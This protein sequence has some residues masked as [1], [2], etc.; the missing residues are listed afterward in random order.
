MTIKLSP[1]QTKPPKARTEFDVHVKFDRD[2]FLRIDQ[3]AREEDRPLSVMVRRIVN[4][5]LAERR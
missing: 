2:T 4:L 1:V 3:M 5:W